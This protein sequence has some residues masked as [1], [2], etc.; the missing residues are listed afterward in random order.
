VKLGQYFV[1]IL[2]PSQI[3]ISKRQLSN[4]LQYPIP[5]FDAIKN[6]SLE[7]GDWLLE[8]IWSLGFG[9]WNLTEPGI[10]Q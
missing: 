3:P 9:D 2:S 8:F 5:K 7:F 4:H 1:T 10:S 6:G